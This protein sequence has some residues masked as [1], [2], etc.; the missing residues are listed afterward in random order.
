MTEVDLQKRV[1]ETLEADGSLAVS[2]LVKRLD[3]DT[4]NIETA[5]SE[6]ES[7]NLVVTSTSGQV[8]GESPVPISKL[9]FRGE[10]TP[11]QSVIQYLYEEQGYGQS[12]IARML[13]Y[14]PGN[15]QTNLDRIEEKIGRDVEQ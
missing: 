7:K 12:Q 3:E 8:R 13:N 11:T 4:E 2:E 9:A 15:V 1:L 5:I 10:L 14:S 6:L